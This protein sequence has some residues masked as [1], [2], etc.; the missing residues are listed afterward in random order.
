MRSKSGFFLL[1]LLSMFVS[2]GF[3]SP[4]TPRW[5]TLPNSAPLPH[6]NRESY[7]EH[8]KARIWY[9]V[10]GKGKPVVLIH[11]GMESADSWGNQVASLLRH[12]RQVILL[13]SRGHGRSSLGDGKLGYE[14]MES[15]VIAV[16]DEL[17]IPQTDVV[18]WSDGANIGLIMAMKNPER[19]DAIYAFGANMNTDAVK[20]NAADAPIIKPVVERLA[21]NYARVSS[22]PGGFGKLHDALDAMQATEPNYTAAQLAAIH[23][24]RIAIVDGD[25]DEFIKGEHTTYLAKTIPNARL[26]ILPNVSHFAPWQDPKEFN[27]SML[28]FLEHDAR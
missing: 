20:P 18:G 2:S 17:K 4:A 27:A 15:D 5:E 6:L 13:D 25:H 26:V 23:G 7:V 12:H 16:M 28:A 3:A 10:V 11:G 22:T 9:G 19:V 24:P 14:R 8:D 1:S 21:A